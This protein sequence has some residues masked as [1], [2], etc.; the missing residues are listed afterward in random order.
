MI[1]RVYGINEKSQFQKASWVPIFFFFYFSF[2]FG[3]TDFEYRK[4]NEVAFSATKSIIIFTYAEQ[5]PKKSENIKFKVQEIESVVDCS[6]LR[7]CVHD[8]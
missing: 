6:A 4:K 7:W 2:F 5:I 1:C 3:W 8:D